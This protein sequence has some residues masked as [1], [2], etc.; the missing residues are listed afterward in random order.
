MIHFRMSEFPSFTHLY[1]DDGFDNWVDSLKNQGY[2][3]VKID[4]NWFYMDEEEY[5]FF[6]LKWG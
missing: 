2:T 6:K 1:M 5:M 3:S 4:D